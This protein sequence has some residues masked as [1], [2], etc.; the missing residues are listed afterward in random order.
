MIDCYSFGGRRC[1]VFPTKIMFNFSLTGSTFD[2]TI[3]SVLSQS[4]LLM[5][6]LSLA[7]IFILY[8]CLFC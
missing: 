6:I 2:K 4:W 1:K 5:V 7:H 8:S 3:I